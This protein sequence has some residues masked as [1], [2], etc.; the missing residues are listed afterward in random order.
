[1]LSRSISRIY[2]AG[3]V[4]MSAVALAVACDQTS[5][6]P[7]SP[8]DD[9]A[10]ADMAVGPDLS[11][12]NTPTVTSVS[13]SSG[14]NNVAQSITIT[15]TD[16]RP[17]AQVTVGGQPCTSPSVTSPTTITC[18]VPAK[19][20][21]CGPRDVVVTHPD[22]GKSGTGI[23]LFTYRS[24]GPV[25]FAAF[26]NYATG[27]GPRRV[28]AV[29]TN[30]D[31]NLDLISVNPT[32]NNITVK[33]GLG[34]GTFPAGASQNL[35]VGT[36]A[37]GP[38][39]LVSGDVN[40]DGK[41]DIVVVNSGTANISVFLNM[42]ASI[43]APPSVIATPGITGAN[44]I[45]IGDISGDG[46]LDL[47][48]ASSGSASV[49]PLLGNGSGG[50]APGTVRAVAG[51]VADIAL[52]DMNADGKLDL[53]TANSTTGN[54]SVCL[55]TGTGTFGNPFNQATGTGASGLFVI[56]LD[57]D[58]KLDV[59]VSNATAMNVSVMTGDG[60]GGL[61]APVNQV[62]APARPESVAVADLSGDGLP[63]IVTANNLDNTVSYLQGITAKQYASPPVNSNSG[64]AP[65]GIIV[66]DFN[67]DRLGDIALAST[68]TNNV[69][70]ALQLC[71]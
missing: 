49:L 51:N 26:A 35:G 13:P 67:G 63:D 62:L 55:G 46:K 2:A 61:A 23:K 31:G 19:A 71:K 65:S 44:A 17:G 22:D 12:Y 14:P 28:V 18:T 58:K 27:T 5:D 8:P 45:A 30:G 15:G 42:G 70:V 37:T 50:F 7:P 32:T 9:L 21:T 43:F 3:V 66:A 59:I 69:Q 60:A 6:P 24:I 41:P 34:D 16:F 64:A 4:G 57:G 11:P 52:A 1:M 48:I 10:M 33:T 47:V 38:A 39:D 68:A 36:G 20:T 25:G 56:D 29:D 54:V 40:G 53:L